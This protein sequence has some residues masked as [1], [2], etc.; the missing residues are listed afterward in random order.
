M[1]ARPRIGIFGCGSIGSYLAR[2]IIQKHSKQFTL[3][4]ICD[5]HPEQCVQLVKALKKRVPILDVTTLIANSDLIVE[6]ACP[7]AVGPLMKKILSAGKSLLVMSAGSFLMDPKLWHL[8]KRH[9]GKVWVPS[10]ALA[11][12]DAI[13]A[14]GQA[15]ITRVSLM[16]EKNPAS[17]VGA[18]FFKIK[19][20][21]CQKIRSRKLLFQG[22]AKDA[23]RL[24]PKNINVAAVLTL[25]V[26]PKVKVEIKL[27]A[28]PKLKTNRHTIEAEG[29]FGK[30]VCMTDN[31]PHVDNPKTSFLAA[32]SPE[33]LLVKRTSLLEVGT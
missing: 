5:H 33:A 3:S 30:I 19:K 10:G 14:A 29:P 27:F 23:V 20:V 18:P 7:E 11:G 9:Q 12:I 16:T 1:T 6:A 21:D 13:L 22:S 17:L 4:G 31:R 2:V 25:A 8:A 24:F 28:D 15:G 32:L 26:G